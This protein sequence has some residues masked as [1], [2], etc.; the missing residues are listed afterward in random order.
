MRKELKIGIF[1]VVVIV[2]SFFLLNYLRGKDIFNKEMEVVAQY[3]DVQG[4][5][6]NR[7]SM[8][9]RSAMECR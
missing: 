2:L 9:A 3:E 8:V 4:L 1:A 6:S 5:F 7:P